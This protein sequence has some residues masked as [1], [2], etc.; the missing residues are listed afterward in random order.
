LNDNDKGKGV[1]LQSIKGTAKGIP[2]DNL[3]LKDYFSP[4][5]HTKWAKN[6]IALD[7]LKFD[8]KDCQVFYFDFH[9]DKTE[10]EAQQLQR[11]AVIKSDEQAEK[12]RKLRADATNEASEIIAEIKHKKENGLAYYD[13]ITCRIQALNPIAATVLNKKLRFNIRGSSD[14][15]PVN[16]YLRE[17]TKV[18]W[19]FL[20]FL[21]QNER[22]WLDV[23]SKDKG[24]ITAMQEIY[25]NHHL[26]N[27]QSYVCLL[28]KRGYTLTTEDEMFLGDAPGS[29]NNDPRNLLL[30]TI[31]NKLRNRSLV[32]IVQ[33]NTSL[34]YILESAQRNNIV[35]FS[36]K[37][38][39]WLAF[40]NNAVHSYGKYW[41]YIESTFRHYG[42][43]DKILEQDKKNVFK[44]KLA[45]LI[46]NMPEQDYSFDEVFKELY[47]EIE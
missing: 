29:K 25:N 8:E 39:Q 28:L 42:I 11:I 44:T 5:V 26:I 41:N 2:G 23:N 27:K 13:P 20:R 47:P 46:G 18:E 33:T 3:I 38:D 16:K 14:L 34:I 9:K 36:Y 22:I 6:S 19:E 30:Y 31:C 24:G 15:P 4:D 1:Y 37:P 12:I 21:L 45:A 32:D 35:E 43:W 40:G 7:A 17:A 10:K